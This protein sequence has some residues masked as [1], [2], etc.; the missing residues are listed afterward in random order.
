M[1]V[2][3]QNIPKQTLLLKMKKKYVLKKST[4]AATKYI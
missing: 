3:Y 2:G 4:A 1:I